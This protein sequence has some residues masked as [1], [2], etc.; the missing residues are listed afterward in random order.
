MSNT[1]TRYQRVATNAGTYEAV[2][3]L[4]GQLAVEQEAREQM[5]EKADQ[6]RK[7]VDRWSTT[8]NRRTSEL[9]AIDRRIAE[10]TRALD[11]LAPEVDEWGI[12]RRRR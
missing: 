4:K 6:A 2:K 3:A 8:Y 5:Q 10:I 9:D 1:E 12:P 7:V 11:V